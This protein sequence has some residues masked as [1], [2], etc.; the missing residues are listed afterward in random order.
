MNKRV[1]IIRLVAF[2]YCHCPEVIKN[3]S[4]KSVTLKDEMR[5]PNRVLRYHLISTDIID[6][7][8]WIT[9]DCKLLS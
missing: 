1:L 9:V 5:S 2:S 8:V 3:I 7:I 6:L 4:V